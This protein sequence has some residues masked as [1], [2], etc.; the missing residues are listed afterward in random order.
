MVG[1]ARAHGAKV[2][3]L[4]L[5]YYTGPADIQE[6]RF[7]ET[8]GPVLDAYF[9]ATHD[10]WY[11]DV[12]HLNH[13]GALVLTDWLAPQVAALLAGKDPRAVPPSPGGP[14]LAMPNDG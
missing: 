11:S 3:F 6:R 12:A 10:E 14:D 1:L 8:F 9:V 4:F 2:A 5:P 13:P 7:Y